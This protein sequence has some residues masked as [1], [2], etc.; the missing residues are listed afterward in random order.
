MASPQKATT[1]LQRSVCHNELNFQ[2]HKSPVDSI[3][4]AFDGLGFLPVGAA[5]AK[6]DPKPG[7]GSRYEPERHPQSCPTMHPETGLKVNTSSISVTG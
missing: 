6:L 4:K 1:S 2:H 7:S 5:Q 3:P